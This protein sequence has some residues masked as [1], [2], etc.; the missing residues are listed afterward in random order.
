MPTRWT[1]TQQGLVTHGLGWRV[2]AG[3]KEASCSIDCRTSR[4]ANKARLDWRRRRRNF[5]SFKSAPPPK[6]IFNSFSFSS[7]GT[8]CC[9]QLSFLFSLRFSAPAFLYL[10]IFYP[11]FLPTT[12]STCTRMGSPTEIWRYF[13]PIMHAR[14]ART[15][16]NA[17]PFPLALLMTCWIGWIDIV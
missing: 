1:C 2:W 11:F 15:L 9:E 8:F 17:H 16:S 13:D 5:I 3:Q 7:C 14:V 6:Y 12:S 4:S 10:C